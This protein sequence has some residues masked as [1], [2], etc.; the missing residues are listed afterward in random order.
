[1]GSLP[2]FDDFSKRRLDF[3]GI[4]REPA[5]LGADG[6]F[7]EFRRAPDEGRAEHADDDGEPVRADHERGDDEYKPYA[8][9]VG[10]AQIT[11]TPFSLDNQW[12]A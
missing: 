8:E 9:H 7:L 5:Q 4:I 6:L 2:L 1:M 3:V 12:K 11:K 10:P